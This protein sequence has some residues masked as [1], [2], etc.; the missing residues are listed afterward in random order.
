[1]N[2]AEQT[3]KTHVSHILEKLAVPSRTQAALY[4]MRIGLVPSN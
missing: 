2:V 4:A 3:I 1:L